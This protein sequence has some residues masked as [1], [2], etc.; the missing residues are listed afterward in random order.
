MRSAAPEA[1]AKPRIGDSSA[2]LSHVTRRSPR[3]G[4]ARRDRRRAPGTRDPPLPDRKHAVAHRAKLVEIARTDQHAATAGDEIADQIMNLRLGRHV[5]ALGRFLQATAPQRGATSHF[6]RITFCWLPPESAPRLQFR[7][8]RADVEKL[9]QSRPRCD[10]RPARRASRC[11]IRRRDWA[12]GCCRA[13]TGSSP[14]RG[15]RSPGT[16]PMPSVIASGRILR[17]G[18]RG[19]SPARAL[20]SATPNSRRMIRSV[21][22]PRR[23]ARPTISRA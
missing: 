6:A 14:G 21:P 17:A 7:P 3:A 5:D 22:L 11:G 9:H 18:A 23:P 2:M 15:D 19:R 16:M 13:P 1:R 10:R 4:A 12:A 8:P 20:G